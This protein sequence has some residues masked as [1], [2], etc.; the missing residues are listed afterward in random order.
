M[1][2]ISLAD[3]AQQDFEAI[4]L[5]Y[6]TGEGELNDE[7][8]F[9]L[10]NIKTAYG[11]L[12]EYPQKQV[13][14]K[15]L[16]AANKQLSE[17]Q[18]LR[19]VNFAQQFFCRNNT[20]DRE[21]IE[22]WFVSVLMQAIADPESSKAQAKNLATLQKYISNLPAEKIDPKLAEKHDIYIQFNIDGNVTTM[23]EKDLSKLQPEYRTRLLER[24]PHEITDVEAEEIL[25]YSK[26]Y[27]D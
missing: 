22:T 2:K 15:K 7:Q 4:N 26:P 11:L 6:T 14:V 8:K 13:T 10:N 18:A 20:I 17:A 24:I 19:Y 16:R 3:K 21:F 9:M 12:L 27:E 23:S 5:Y 25:N 1:S